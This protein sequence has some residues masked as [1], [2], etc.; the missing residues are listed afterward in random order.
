MS[1][2]C[3]IVGACSKYAVELTA[4][5][6]SLDFVGNK[7]DVHII[8]I[9]LPE[10]LVR[11][12]DNLNYKTIHHNISEEEI[13]ESKGISEV[14]C[15]KRYWYGAEIGKDYRAINIL[16]ADLIFC[17]DPILYFEIAEKTGFILGVSKEQNKVYDEEHHLVNGKWSW[18]T[19]RGFY[20]DKDLC[21]CPLFL[22][23]KVWGDALRLSWDVF[24]NG[25]FKAPDMDALALALLE[26]DS[27][28]KTIILPNISW[29]GVNEKFYK[30][31]IRATER[32]GLLFTESGEPIFSYH[33]HMGHLIWRETQL[34]NRHHCASTYL[35]ANKS[36]EV[37]EHLD[38]QAKGS[39]NLLYQRFKK[40]FH[41]N[42]KI[43]PFNYRHPEES[44][45]R[46]YGDL[47]E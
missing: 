47:W 6:N 44:Y 26:Y 39:L 30:P 21:N 18:N 4:L 3:Y 15:R 17:R 13:K 29:L 31:Y 9:H 38:N 43:P 1:D 5:L 36:Q 34:A 7:E 12:L 20:N 16:D 37:Q 41:Y 24:I 45:K 22:D 33:G 8:G 11:Q 10:E 19:A 25:G 32:R 27:Y 40:M 14:T 23:A 35:K 2:Y 46:E 28:D 42:I